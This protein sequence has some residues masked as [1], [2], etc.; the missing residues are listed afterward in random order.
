MLITSVISGPV[1]SFADDID[2]RGDFDGNSALEVN[3]ASAILDYVLGKKNYNGNLDPQLFNYMADVNRDNVITASDAAEVLRKALAGGF[4]ADYEFSGEKPQKPVVST[5]STSNSEITTEAGTESTTEVG[6]G[7]TTEAGTESTTEVGTEATTEVGTEATT[8]AGTEATTEASTEATTEAG[9]EATTEEVVTG[10]PANAVY[11]GYDAIVDA[12]IAE[13][14]PNREK[15]PIFKTVREALNAAPSDRTEGNSYVIGIVPGLYREHIRVNKPYITFKKVTNSTSAAEDATLTWYWQTNYTYDNIGADGDVDMSMPNKDGKNQMPNWGRSTWVQSGATGFRAEG[16]YFEN[17]ANLYMT[18]E[19]KDANVRPV[20]GSG[21]P[22]RIQLPVGNGSTEETDAS[23]DMYNERSCALYTEAD[24]AV[25]VDC[26]VI[27]TQDSLGTGGRAYFKNCYLAGRTDFICGGGQILF[28]ECNIHWQ[29]SKWNNSGSDLTAPSTGDKEHGYLFYNC[30]VTG[31]EKTT[32]VKF[33]RPWGSGYNSEA[34]YVNTVL[35]ESPVNKGTPI[36]DNNKTGWDDMS[37]LSTDAKLFEYNTTCANPSITID[38][39]KRKG[40]TWGR[41]EKGLLDDFTVVKYNPY[42]WTAF[43]EGTFDGWDPAGVVEKWQKIEAEQDKIEFAESYTENFKLPEAPA[44]YEVKYYV[45]SN[46]VKI[47]EDGKTAEVTRPL[48]SQ[49][50]AEVEFTIY[51]K[52]I[53]TIDGVEFIRSTKIKAID[54]S[55]GNFKTKGK[56]TVDFPQE[57]DLNVKLS[58][59]TAAGYHAADKEVVIPKGQTSVDYA[60]EAEDGNAILAAGEYNVTVTIDNNLISVKGGEVKNINGEVDTDYPL[61][62]ELGVLETM[63]GTAGALTG[64]PSDGYTMTTVSD[65]DKGEVYHFKKEASAAV[66]AKQK[67]VW[68]LA[69]L[70]GSDI[71]NFKKADQIRVNFS[72]KIPDVKDWGSNLNNYL[73]IIG[74]AAGDYKGE[75]DSSR[76]IRMG[77][78]GHWQQMDVISNTVGGLSGSDDTNSQ[79]LNVYGKFKDNTKSWVDIT[80]TL[81]YKNNEVV[82]SSKGG[83]GS[84]TIKFTDKDGIPSGIDRGILNF[85]I[86][87]QDS[88]NVANDEYYITKPSISYERFIPKESTEGVD[89]TGSATKDNVKAVTLINKN[90]PLYKHN[91]VIGADGIIS[92]AEKIPAG[93]YLIECT[94]AEGAKTP[95]ITGTGVTGDNGVYT[96]TVGNADITDLSIVSEKV[97]GFKDA[98]DALTKYF[99]DNFTK[100][101]GGAYVLDTSLKLPEVTGYTIKI[102]EATANVTADGGIVRGEAGTIAAVNKLYFTIAIAGEGGASEDFPVDVFVEPKTANVFERDFEELP[103]GTKIPANDGFVG[104]IVNGIDGGKGNVIEFSSIKEDGTQADG[105]SLVIGDFGNMDANG[106]YAISF[107]VMKDDVSNYGWRLQLNNSLDLLYD[108]GK[109]N[110]DVYGGVGG[111]GGYSASDVY[112]ASKNTLTGGEAKKWYNITVVSNNAKSHADVYLNGTYVTSYKCAPDTTPSNLKFGPYYGNLHN[113][114][115]YVDNIKV[116]RLDMDFESQFNTAM[117]D[118][119]IPETVGASEVNVDLPLKTTDGNVISWSK[120]KGDDVIAIGSDGKAVFKP[121]QGATTAALTAVVTN[122]EATAKYPGCQNPG[123]IN[124]IS[125]SKTYD[126]AFEKN[127]TDSFSVKGNVNFEIAPA[128]DVDVKIEV[129]KGEEVQGSAVVT[130]PA[131]QTS[132]DYTILK[133]GIDAEIVPGEYDVKTS[134]LTADVDNKVRKV[135]DASG[136]EISKITGNKDDEVVVNVTVGEFGEVPFTI[137]FEDE[138]AKGQFKNN[139]SDA[140]KVAVVDEPNATQ[141]KVLKLTA[142][143]ASNGEVYYWNLIDLIDGKK[144]PDNIDKVSVSYK[145]KCAKDKYKST[146]DIGYGLTTKLDKYAKD[147]LFVRADLGGQ[148]NQI[149]YKNSSGG[150]FVAFGDAAFTKNLDSTQNYTNWYDISLDID[151]ANSLL[152]GKIETNGKKATFDLANGGSYSCSFG[153]STYSYPTG[154]TGRD[155]ITLAFYPTNDNNTGVEWYMDDI[156]ISYEDWKTPATTSSVSLDGY[157]DGYIV[158]GSLD[159]GIVNVQLQSKGDI[160][161]TYNGTIIDN[162]RFKIENVPAGEY[163]VIVETAAGKDITFVEGLTVT[164]EG[165]TLNVKDNV[166]G[167]KI[168]TEGNEEINLAMADEVI[169][170]TTDTDDKDTASQEIDADNN[171]DADVSQNLNDEADEAENAENQAENNENVIT[172]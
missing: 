91:S 81:D 135:A 35:D 134:I 111:C 17:S 9:T 57:S 130:M 94:L 32:Y 142:N 2:D 107:D 144:L 56:I 163:D 87:P 76:Y 27:G 120:N 116:D 15:Q 67:F 148:W 79:K 92:F 47:S 132:K 37:C 43:K 154:I 13:S 75:A 103:T 21:K 105:A 1:L 51:L 136:N 36:I 54:T 8:E 100:N 110:F 164:D 80:V 167:I 128:K 73:D 85:V 118:I 121:Q 106:V 45:D 69:A 112:G 71:E 169:D 83:S 149:N 68:D 20:P 122:N 50:D 7:A 61:N 19:E 113:A 53:G 147:N 133:D 127:A 44:G 161:Y 146:I 125:Y 66:D 29:S 46:F 160:I 70:A 41:F 72:L 38:T 151:Y 171:A 101:Q 60:V 124:T 159:E 31:G 96:I 78:R 108:Q 34:V 139:T 22:E 131:G 49:P 18:Q 52:K 10:E 126:I 150:Q 156:T 157:S 155:D 158:K 143:G 40:A 16:I 14:N 63:S 6:T 137:N 117:T 4:D 153:N 166:G 168:S 28:D 77:I 99:D 140:L 172:E 39:S 97:S 115:I 55:A 95:A 82:M 170:E 58:F 145:L 93:T 162:S 104:K 30:R 98:E 5:E 86:Y 12:R 88:S 129:L 89:V 65:A 24:K 33:G 3:D 48:Y 42:T 109:I 138:N 23:A 25:F 119:T 74:G 90:Q 123:V 141:N 102:K 59:V 152:A 165:Y 11:D 62:I 114:K 26:K 84:K 64:T